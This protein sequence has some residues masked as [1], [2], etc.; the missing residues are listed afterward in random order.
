M[1]PACCGQCSKSPFLEMDVTCL[2]A[3]QPTWSPSPSKETLPEQIW[4]TQPHAFVRS[5]SAKL[6]AVFPGYSPCFLTWKPSSPTRLLPTEAESHYSQ[7]GEAQTGP[8]RMFSRLN[9]SSSPPVRATPC[10]PSSPLAT[11]TAPTRWGNRSTA[12]PLMS[13][14]RKFCQAKDSITLDATHFQMCLLALSNPMAN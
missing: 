12:A 9:A 6:T 10:H 13:P 1:T 8:Q 11:R 4:C 7:L 2:Q 5:P 3:N 14:T